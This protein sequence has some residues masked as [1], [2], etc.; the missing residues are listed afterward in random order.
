MPLLEIDKKSASAVAAVLMLP[1][2]R[3][4]SGG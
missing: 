2:G 3:A 1:V 4:K